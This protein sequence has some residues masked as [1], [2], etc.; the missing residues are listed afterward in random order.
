MGWVWLTT[1][2]EQIDEKCNYIVHGTGWLWSIWKRCRKGEKMCIQNYYACIQYNVYNWTTLASLTKTEIIMYC[3]NVTLAPLNTPDFTFLWQVYSY[4]H[5]SSRIKLPSKLS[6]CSPVGIL[7]YWYIWVVGTFFTPFICSGI[8]R[9]T[10]RNVDLNGSLTLEEYWVV[11]QQW[12][13]T[14]L[15][16]CPISQ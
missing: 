16:S 2:T 15:R 10:Q 13:H 1:A 4:S 3:Q 12:M 11:C 5:L 7:K 6:T 9:I 14:V 8:I